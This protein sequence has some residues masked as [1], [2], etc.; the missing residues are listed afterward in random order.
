MSSVRPA[1]TS[2]LPWYRRP[3]L[4]SVALA[5]W[6]M[7]LYGGWAYLANSRHGPH[8]AARAAATQGF[9]SFTLTLVMTAVMEGLHRLGS[10]R[11]TRFL[12]PAGGALLLGGAYSV[13]AHFYMGTPEVAGTVVPILLLGGTYALAYSANLARESATDERATSR[14]KHAP[15]NSA[16]QDK[17]T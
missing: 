12:L 13:A 5:L 2:H 11:A 6:A 4:R 1:P 14:A 16:E 17:P 3:L 9:I 15:E 7:L 10:R 8:A